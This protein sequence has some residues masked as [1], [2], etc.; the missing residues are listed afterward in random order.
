MRQ[1]EAAPP[2][3][4]AQALEMRLAILFL[5]LASLARLLPPAIAPH[6]F[7]RGLSAGLSI[8]SIL[9]FAL[10]L[11]RRKPVPPAPGPDENTGT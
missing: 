7:A 2:P 9:C 4:F 3:Y 5:V 8:A 11:L 6:D 1:P 10:T